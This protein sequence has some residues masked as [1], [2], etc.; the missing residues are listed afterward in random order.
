M[1]K[2]GTVWAFLAI[3]ITMTLLYIGYNHDKKYGSY[4][5]LEQDINEAASIYLDANEIKLSIG[6]KKI[7]NIEDLIKTN[8]LKDE[9]IE[10][11]KCHGYVIVSKK[12]MNIEYNPYIK[13]KK[14][15]TP[16][17]DKDNIK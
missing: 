12:I 15:T 7:I 11:D 6:N 10:K 1:K 9:L 16:E 14:Y 8:V 2:V 17:Y 13:C 5:A 4:F 3:T